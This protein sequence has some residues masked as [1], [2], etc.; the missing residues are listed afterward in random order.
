M[1][2]RASVAPVEGSFTFPSAGMHI[3]PTLHRR[4]S[5]TDISGT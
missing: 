4:T 3:H 2:L 5:P 1:S